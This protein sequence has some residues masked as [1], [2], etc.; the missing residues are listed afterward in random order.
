MINIRSRRHL[1]DFRVLILKQLLTVL[2]IKRL[3]RS[4][5]MATFLFCASI[6]AAE[7]QFVVEERG[8]I[9][10]QIAHVTATKIFVKTVGGDPQRDLLFDVS[11]QTLFVIE[12]RDRSYLQ[13]DNQTIN[14]VAALIDSVSGV[15]ESQQGVLS[16]LLSTFGL[17]EESEL[18]IAELRDSGKQLSIVG[19]SCQLH[20]AH[21]E[22]ELNFE[23]CVANNQALKLRQAE[24][25]ALREFF[26]FSNRLQNKAGKL[27]SV[28]GLNLP[29]MNLSETSGLP[30]GMHSPSQ[31][32][33][34]RISAIDSELIPPARSIPSGY[35]RSEIPLISG[36]S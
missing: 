21:L 12:H 15:V 17:S 25:S 4:G 34:V 26:L 33:K 19:Y 6:D 13:V 24:F 22:G 3:V 11:S 9:V 2:P 5:M 20:Q 32:L 27:L 18:P 30:I 31:G 14:E 10:Q 35:T 28:L 7:I 8:R 1:K 36:Q 29:K 16:D 23:I